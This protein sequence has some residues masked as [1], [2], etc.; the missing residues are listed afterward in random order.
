MI[1]TIR[2]VEAVYEKGYLRPL[3]PLEA[4][5]GLVYIVTVLD[6]GTVR[7]QKRPARSWR[8]KYRGYLSTSVEFSGGKLQEKLLE[9]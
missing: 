7:G 4:R 5:E 1:P 2:T 6:V 9:R 3:Q 8:G